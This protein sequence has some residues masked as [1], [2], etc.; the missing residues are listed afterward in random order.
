MKT[1][2]I[3]PG[4]VAIAFLAGTFIGVWQ[5]AG[6]AWGMLRE[7][8]GPLAEMVNPPFFGTFFGHSFLVAIPIALVLFTALWLSPSQRRDSSQASR[9]TPFSEIR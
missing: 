9:P 5:S 3:Q 8:L 6:A 1:E 7:G 2:R 4:L